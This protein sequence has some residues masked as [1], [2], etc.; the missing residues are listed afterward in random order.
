MRDEDH[1]RQL[2]QR[3]RG[4]AR[5]GPD[6]SAQPYPPDRPGMSDDLRKRIQA[7]VAA[8]RANA[9]QDTEHAAASSERG[10]PAG[11]ADAGEHTPMPQRARG[12]ARAGPDRSAPP[13]PP[14]RP[15]MSDDL[16]KRIQAAVAA[17]RAN[18]AQNT[19]HA[20]ASSER[21]NPAGTTGAGEH[22]PA[23]NLINRKNGHETVPRPQRA[24]QRSMTRPR[25]MRLIGVIAVAL[26]AAVGSL[27]ALA[28]R[29]AGSKGGATVA[30]SP[31]PLRQETALRAEAAA[32]VAQ[33]VSPGVTVSCD[34]AMCAVLT[35]DAFPAR[36][37]LVLS[38][39]SAGPLTSA[40]IVATS[41]VRDMFGS[42][43][44]TAIAPGVLASF[45]SGPAEITVRVVAPRGVAAYWAALRAGQAA[46]KTNGSALLND[47]RITVSAIAQG[48][49][50]GGQVDSRLLL[51]VASL[52][53]NEPIDI[54]QFGNIG[55][56]V[57]PEIPLRFADLASND[58]AAHL[59][60][61]AYLQSLRAFLNKLN[62]KFRPA[63]IM[64]VVRP[65]RRAVLRVEF[66][67]PSPLGLFGTQ[68]LP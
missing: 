20:A 26:A 55:P 52:A 6:R 17:E 13:H 38:P 21:G 39:T 28:I 24:I 33:Q 58:Q 22:N 2:P 64:Q 46:R 56:G 3:A 65:G 43:L 27:L 63:R 5:A 54:V 23:P 29:P 61:A 59:T 12:A 49:L 67:A 47:P 36:N 34:P 60:S 7:S 68:G 44:S 31:A 42:S 53:T 25:R 19:E 32:W 37:L 10:N 1:S 57:G 9:A 48:Q 11:T 8:E 50:A 35:D 66:T 41:A 16:R 45:G 30:F 18:A 40:V 51:A 14:D 4:A 62:T 15:G